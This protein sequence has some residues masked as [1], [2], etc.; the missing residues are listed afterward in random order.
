M[1]PT[2]RA[3]EGLL[4]A[5]TVKVPHLQI[6]AGEL[7]RSRAMPKALQAVCCIGKLQVWKS[8]GSIKLLSAVLAQAKNAAALPEA[9]HRLTPREQDA[10]YVFLSRC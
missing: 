2:L 8:C 6:F 3:N 4:K 1:K 7:K 5:R 9:F 10:F